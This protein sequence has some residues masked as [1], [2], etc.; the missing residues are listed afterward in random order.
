MLPR[1]C[2][3]AYSAGWAKTPFYPLLLSRGL[4]GIELAVRRW[5]EARGRL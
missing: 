3:S 4:S 1:I 5:D 2:S